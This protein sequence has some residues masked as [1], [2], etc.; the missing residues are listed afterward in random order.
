MFLRSSKLSFA[1]FVLFIV[2][3]ADAFTLA[4]P[5]RNNRIV[6]STSWKM[7]SHSNNHVM[8]VGSANQDLI[9]ITTVVP[10]IGETVMGEEFSISCGGKGANQAVA[11]ACLKISP[12]SIVCRVGDDIFGKNLLDNFRKHIFRMKIMRKLPLAAHFFDFVIHRTSRCD[13]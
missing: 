3:H 9:S 8:V 2:P 11:A 4:I 6:T 5:H 10:N 12:V 7:S 1:F 13:I